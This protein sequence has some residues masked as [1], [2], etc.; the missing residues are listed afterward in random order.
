M[1]VILHQCIPKVEGQSSSHGCYMDQWDFEFEGSN[2]QTPYPDH[3][4]PK[5]E[6]VIQVFNI[7]CIV[8]HSRMGW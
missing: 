5:N 7:I 6:T 3:Q 2:L 1:N 4:Y 8:E